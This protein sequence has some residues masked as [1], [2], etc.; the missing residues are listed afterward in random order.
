MRPRTTG[1]WGNR[2]LA[3]AKVANWC[4]NNVERMCALAKK[5][6]MI[7]R[8][9]TIALD[10]TN[11]PYYGKYFKDKTIKTKPKSGTARFFSYMVAHTTDQKGNMPIG[12]MRITKDDNMTSITH[13]MLKKMDRVGARPGLVLADRGFYSVD[14]INFMKRDG[15]KFVMPAVK[16][17]R[18]KKAILEHHEGKRDAASTFTMSN[19]DGEQARFNLLIVEKDGDKKPDKITDRYVV[20]ATNLPCRTREELIEELPETYRNRWIVETGFRMIKDA[21]GKTCS[22]TYHVR[23]FLFHVALMLYGLWR[24]VKFTDITFNHEQAGGDDYTMDTFVSLMGSMTNR[25]I[26]WQRLREDS[27]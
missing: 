8:G 6:G 15:R 18:I 4:G 21:L 23:L 7:R 14:W 9:C 11:I 20:F 24:V 25:Q 27:L 12:C 3:P 1:F 16:N 10:A 17:P 22:R 5:A 2:D 13:K 26:T 19:K